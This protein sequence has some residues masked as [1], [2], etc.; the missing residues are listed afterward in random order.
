MDGDDPQ[1]LLVSYLYGD[2]SGALLRHPV[3]GPPRGHLG[4]GLLSPTIFNMVVGAVIHPW[5][6]LVAEEEAGPDVFGR[7]VQWLVGSFY[8]DNS[9][10]V[11]PRLAS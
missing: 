8:A 4:G 11:S 1:V 9:L 10:L 6:T 2:Q 7:A 5:F 3:Q